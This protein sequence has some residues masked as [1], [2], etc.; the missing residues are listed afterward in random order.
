MTIKFS[1]NKQ[2]FYDENTDVIPEDAVV[3]TDEQHLSLIS[4]MNDGERRVYIGKNGELTLSDSKPSQWHTWDS[5][6]NAW[7]ISDTEREQAAK[8]DA[9]NMRSALRSTADT[10]IS[11][12][13]DAVDAGIATDEETA[14]L[15]EWKKYRIMLMRV[16][17]AKPL[18]PMPPGGQAS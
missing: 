14:A 8:A 13:Q 2:A 12:R 17:T 3:I 5:D 4:G 6:N 16:N 7:V 1:V 11:W 18:W 9:E 15:S 10:E